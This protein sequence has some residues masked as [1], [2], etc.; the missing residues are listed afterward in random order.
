MWSPQNE[1]PAIHHYQ[2]EGRI[3]IPET[4]VTCPQNQ[5]RFTKPCQVENAPNGDHE[6]KGSRVMLE[7][8]PVERGSGPERFHGI[9]WFMDK[10][11]E[12]PYGNK[13]RYD[14]HPEDA[15]KVAFE[16]QHEANG[17]E[18]PGESADGIQALTKA[19]TRSPYLLR[20]QVRN[21]SVPW[22][23]SHAFPNPVD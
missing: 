16:T 20:S 9:R 10:K 3:F 21:E 6:P 11:G 8:P 14:G 1:M 22:R 12:Q 18:W 17:G 7:F 23:T 19:V 2:N 13:R 5:E 4:E 15:A